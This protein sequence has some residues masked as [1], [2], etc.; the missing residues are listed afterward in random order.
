M[1]ARSSGRGPEAL[2][3][4]FSTRTPAFR[5]VVRTLEKLIDVDVNVLVT[6][7]SG[8]GKDY[9]AEALHVCGVRAARPFVRIDC[10]SIPPDLFE[11][12]LFGFEKGTFTDAKANKPGRLESVRGGTLYLDEI[13]GIPA[14][15]QAKLLRVIEQRQ[16]TRLGGTRPIELD[17]RI[18]ASATDLEPRR[19]GSHSLR[20]DLLYRLSVVTIE[21]PP[22]R[23][24]VDDIAALARRFARDAAA[25]HHR[26]R[27][28]LADE[29][30][31]LLSAYPW[32]GNVRELASV[33]DRAVVLEDGSELTPAS[34][35]RETLLRGDALVASASRGLW[36]LAELERRYA[37][38]VLDSVG[39]NGSRAA[40]ILGI[41]RKTLIEK[42][43]R[44]GRAER[45]K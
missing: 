12:E 38:A 23:E 19:Q 40:K 32:P 9:V 6:G 31:A 27:R 39:G 26:P 3:R 4:L 28:P 10:S 5:A 24:R 30:L 45:A 29:T 37:L 17:A 14:A 18:I 21:L 1:P 25:R 35:P 7:E 44:W 41:S 36:T 22:L 15:L 8:S 42:R 11:S 43:R 2:R 34:L 20:G 16:F 13:G 33:V